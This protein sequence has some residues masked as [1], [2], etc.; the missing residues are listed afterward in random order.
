MLEIDGAAGGGQILRTALAFSV[1]NEQPF[2]MTNIRGNRPN[3][4]L[5]PQHRKGVEL[6]RRLSDAEVEGAA[7]DSQTL[8]F[9]PG[10]FEPRDIE[11]DIGTAG[12]ISL[13]FQTVLP[14]CYA[15]ETEFTVQ[16]RGGTEV[17][18]SPPIHF[19]D[20]VTLPVLSQFGV[21]AS[22]DIRRHGFYPK[23][24]GRASLTIRPSE[25]IKTRMMVCGDL[26]RITGVSVASEHLRDADVTDRQGE[27]ATEL[28]RQQYPETEVD[29][30]RRYAE[31]DSPGSSLVLAAECGKTV[32]G[33]D[34]L[35]EKG[36]PS[37]QVASEAADQLEGE[38][39]SEAVLDRYTADQA[40]PCLGVSKGAI[41]VAELTD[42]V[43]T[44]MR[45][46]EKFLEME[47][48]TDSHELVEVRA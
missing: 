40:I 3:P 37:E 30:D 28:L 14:L 4:G 45:V 2:R 1:L 18:W 6:M 23:G 13:L 38:L 48:E 44:N 31:S 9:A 33:A 43:E 12:S 8:T 46:V 22:L 21:D 41:R 27:K 32:L 20:A 29:I 19:L 17:K 42:H 10:R 35:G 39:K 26:Q 11:I 16:A 34:S 36:K 25:P 7:Q 15:T 24:G 5:K 47:F